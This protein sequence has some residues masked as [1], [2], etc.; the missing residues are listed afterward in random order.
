MNSMSQCDLWTVLV[1]FMS[2]S[3]TPFFFF[4]FYSCCIWFCVGYLY[5]NNA[6]RKRIITLFLKEHFRDSSLYNCINIQMIWQYHNINLQK[7]LRE[8]LWLQLL[9]TFHLTCNNP[10]PACL[11]CSGPGLSPLMFHRLHVTLKY[12]SLPIVGKSICAYRVFSTDIAGVCI[13][14]RRNRKL[15]LNREGNDTE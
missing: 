6:R 10:E 8:R 13:P 1:S 3:F 11:Q 4:N 7:Q 5:I 15:C 2:V 12:R 14:Q 9:I